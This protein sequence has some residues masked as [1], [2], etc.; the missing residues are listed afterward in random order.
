M[1]SEKFYID[2]HRPAH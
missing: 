1:K 2:M